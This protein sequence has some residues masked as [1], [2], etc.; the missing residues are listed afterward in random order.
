MNNSEE[1][2]SRA[3]STD[4]R[5]SLLFHLDE[6]LIAISLRPAKVAVAVVH[7]HRRRQILEEAFN[8][9]KDVGQG[10]HGGGVGAIGAE[11]DMVDKSCVV[12]GGDV[13]CDVVDC[14]CGFCDRR[15]GGLGGLAGVV[16]HGH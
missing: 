8:A 11:G 5:V 12:G 10:A 1:L 9:W 14:V 6:H 4:G 16:A 13:R 7:R 3:I 2:L 15:R